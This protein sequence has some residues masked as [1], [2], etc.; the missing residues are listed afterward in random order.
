[1]KLSRSLCLAEV[2]ST[3]FSLLCA[4]TLEYNIEKECLGAALPIQAHYWPDSLH[5]VCNQHI[6]RLA[7]ARICRKKSAQALLLIDGR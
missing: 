5:P 7:T 4:S 2:V 3:S 1:M 6:L